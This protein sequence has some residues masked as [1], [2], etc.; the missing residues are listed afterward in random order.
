MPG[1]G[2]GNLARRPLKAKRQR[3][4]KAPAERRAKRRKSKE[5]AKLERAS[6]EENLIARAA[7]P[8]KVF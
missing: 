7:K 3:C 5:V 1:D 2:E 6:G 8:K 4:E